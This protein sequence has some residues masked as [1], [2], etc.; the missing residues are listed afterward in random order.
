[1]SQ[2]THISYPRSG[3][4]LGLTNG[5]SATA[6]PDTGAGPIPTTT[7]PTTVD[8]ASAGSNCVVVG[9]TGSWC[10]FIPIG[11]ADAATFDMRVVLWRDATK[12]GNTAT[13]LWVPVHVAD[14]TV[15]C[16]AK[17]GIAGA[18]LTASHA[19][20]DTITADAYSDT[21]ADGNELGI[22]KIHSPQADATGANL[23]GL[24]SIRTEGFQKIGLYFD[25]A[26]GAPASLVNVIYAFR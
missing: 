8:A 12:A 19:F 21:V 18:I 9:C 5:S 3:F 4:T 1:M 11:D 2:P 15:T 20:A 14:L 26:G 7:E 17:V 23:I 13:T 25:R 24:V 22:V 6:F 16:G 10:D